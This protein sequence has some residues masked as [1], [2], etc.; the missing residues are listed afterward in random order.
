MP[1]APTG[2]TVF[3]NLLW[4]GAGE[5]AIKLVL[6]AIALLI[7]RVAGEAP[8]GTFS[9]GYNTA[10]VLM[11][12]LSFGQVETLIREVAR[13][14]GSAGSLLTASLA[15][16]RGLVVRL[17]PLSL[18]VALTLVA[19]L[20][21]VDSTLRATLVAFLPYAALRAGM[22]VRAAPFKGLDQ[23]GIETRARII[24]GTVAIAVTGLAVVLHAPTW[25]Y[26]L[27]LAA[28]TLTAWAWLRRQQRRLERGE[29]AGFDPLTEGWPFLVGALITIL[30]L[31]A[32]LFLLELLGAG[33]AQ[34]GLYAAASTVIWAVLLIPQMMALA[35]YPTLTRQPGRFGTVL[36][37][38]GGGALLGALAAAALS[39]AAE[40]LIL[41]LFGASFGAS[42]PL[43]GRLAWALPGACASMLLGILLAAR[44]RQQVTM[45]LQLV[46]LLGLVGLDLVLIPSGGAAAAA[47]VAVWVHSGI[48][49]ALAAAMAFLP[50]NLGGAERPKAPDWSAAE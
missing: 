34:V 27:T 50:P 29:I 22:V 46:G 25:C 19:V 7:A 47:N 48:A 2:K 43:M 36:V 41:P 44:G 31:R 5:A 33:R 24:E 30:L 6:V 28:G 9:L 15:M 40:P 13:R 1:V 26:G 14:P 39:L 37:V 20:I 18:L 35:I 23:M 38:G 8:L 11:V 16:R 10:L 4:L 42:V 12:L 3:R 45:R 49:L 32:D 17:W 21:Q